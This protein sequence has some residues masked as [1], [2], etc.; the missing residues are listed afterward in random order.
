MKF[1]LK[2]FFIFLLIFFSSAVSF[3][4]NRFDHASLRIADEIENYD[5]LGFTNELN[6]YFRQRPAQNTNTLLVHLLA[7]QHAILSGKLS[8]GE[9]QIQFARRL[10]S[11]LQPDSLKGV[12]DYVEGL[13]Y[14]STDNYPI[15][16]KFLNKAALSFNN[17]AQTLLQARCFVMRGLI[18]H[19]LHYTDD[20][21]KNI[22]IALDYYHKTKYAKREAALL[23][24]LALINTQRK[25]SATAS[26]YLFRSLAL[27]DSIQDLGGIGQCYNNLGALMYNFGHYQQALDY[28]EKGF[29]YRK[30]A[31]LTENSL[32]ESKINIGKTYFKLGKN[33]EALNYLEPA[34]YATASPIERLEL[35]RLATKELKEIYLSMKDY[36]RAYEMQDIYYFAKDSLYGVSKKEEI[37]RLS[38]QYNFENKQKQDSLQRVERESAQKTLQE[39]KDKRSNFIMIA[40]LAGLSIAALFVYFLYKSNA[41]NKKNNIIISAQRDILDKKQ[42]EITESIQYAHYI[43]EA[44]LPSPELLNKNLPQHFIL[45][46]PKD[47]V[48]GDFYWHWSSQDYQLLAVADCTGHGVP[49]A[50]MSLLG[51]ESLDKS[52]VVSKNPGEILAQ[53]N[54]SV[55]QSLKQNSEGAGSR[56]GM[57]IALLKISGS[58]GRQQVIYSGANRPLWI[59]RKN[60]NELQEIKATKSAIGGFTPDN[61]QFAEN[62]IEISA[63]DMLYLFT[64]GFADQFGGAKG[65]KMTTKKFRELLAGI[66]NFPVETQKQKLSAFFDEWKS[67]LEQV[68][69]ILII[70]IRF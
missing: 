22:L 53:L 23:N 43:Q 62:T 12:A 6:A 1:R 45:Y 59:F 40:L 69:D 56:D 19:T 46:R 52:V 55:K 44:L 24:N 65:K 2:Y 41:E 57:D 31:N 28:Y 13:Y 36:K 58:A 50:F 8:V 42:Q 67:V 54:R 7:A 60:E 30:Q 11:L 4:Q 37:V 29:D 61:Q 68:D 21:E 48:S 15:A 33:K 9:Q 34:F 18:F 14:F 70:G 3:A 10:D 25:D 32:I 64:D 5:T 51:K 66:H 35:R 16:L 49:G 38:V 63:G 26:Y 39:E 47:I 17:K 20:A 27:R